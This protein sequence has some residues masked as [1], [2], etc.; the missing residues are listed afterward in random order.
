M[1][2][3]VVWTPSFLFAKGP[4]ILQRINSGW[5]HRPGP[6]PLV[7]LEEL[8]GRHAGVLL[9]QSP[10]PARGELPAPGVHRVAVLR[11]QDPRVHA[12]VL[13]RGE[14]DGED[15]G[16]GAEVLDL[17]VVEL[18]E[19]GEGLLHLVDGTGAVDELE[20]GL[21]LGEDVAGDE[22]EEGDGL[23]G[24]GGHLEEAVAAGVEGALELHHVRVL[25]RVDVVVGEVDGHVLDFELHFFFFSSSSSVSSASIRSRG[26][27]A[28]GSATAGCRRDSPAGASPPPEE[29][30]VARG[31][32]R[33]ERERERESE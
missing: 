27:R 16:G 4:Q 3:Q 22:G 12:Q 9:G 8:A 29:E 26:P 19:L 20:R 28:L 17:V 21:G 5:Q 30:E 11:R 14:P 25:L 7:V 2:S 24:A 13:A 23:A 1:P 15:P 18:L 32:K 6:G 10:N 31:F 33:D